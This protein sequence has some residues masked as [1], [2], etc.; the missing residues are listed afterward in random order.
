MSRIGPRA[1]CHRQQPCSPTWCTSRGRL[2][3]GDPVPSPRENGPEVPLLP[4]AEVVT[5]STSA[6]PWT[7]EPGLRAD[8]PG[9]RR[10]PDRGSP[11]HPARP[12]KHGAPKWCCSLYAAPEAALVA[13]SSSSAALLHRAVQAGS[14]SRRT[15]EA[16]SAARWAPRL[17]L[18][19]KT[20]LLTLGEGDTPLVA[21]LPWPATSDAPSSG[22][23]RG[24]E[25]P[26]SFK[27]RGMV[28][29][30]AKPWRA[31]C[32][33]RSAP[34]PAIPPPARRRTARRR[35]SPARVGPGG[36]G[37]AGKDGAGGGARSAHR[38]LRGNFDAAL[39]RVREVA[40]R[41]RHRALNSVTSPST[42]KTAVFPSMRWD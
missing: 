15:N 7:D 33:A 11:R 18:T 20:P 19:E 35:G 9:A 23:V 42:Q 1:R 31:V 30:V 14:A 25:P 39:V 10:A 32:A 17:P 38:R 27:D 13:P 41:P 37:R 12:G 5:R 40:A 6:S 4:M 26:G 36:Q 34:R 8:H 24:A 3:L 2:A 16:R 22:S 28:V 21:A 29:A